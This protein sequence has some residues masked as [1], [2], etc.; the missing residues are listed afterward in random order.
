MTLQA[1]SSLVGKT[2]FHTNEESDHFSI[3]TRQ[4]GDSCSCTASP[5]DIEQARGIIRFL[6]GKGV[7]SSLQVVDEWVEVIVM[8][9]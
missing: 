8:K 9:K 5:Y 2:Y 3:W 1:L 4:N 7:T 6:K